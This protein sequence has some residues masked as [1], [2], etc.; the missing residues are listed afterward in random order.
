M[1][2]Q[3]A[4]LS[5]APETAPV[6]LATLHK[7]DKAVVAGV[8]EDVDAASEGLGDDAGSTLLMRLVEIG[9]VAG[10]QVEV[11]GEARPGGDPIAVRVGGTTFALRRREARAVLVSRLP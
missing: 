3:P 6:S 11:I 1:N 8:A 2:A 5:P 7:G 4:P 10:E 9:F